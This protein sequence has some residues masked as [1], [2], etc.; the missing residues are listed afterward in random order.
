MKIEKNP[1]TD[2][3]FS[4]LS[5]FKIAQNV[6]FDKNRGKYGATVK[7]FH[8]SFHFGQKWASSRHLMEIKD[9]SLGNRRK[10]LFRQKSYQIRRKC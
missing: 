10:C 8:F 6:H 2:F 1:E 9:L 7:P 3:E 4:I 5:F